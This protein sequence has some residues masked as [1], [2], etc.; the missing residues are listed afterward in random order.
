MS[1]DTNTNTQRENEKTLEEVVNFWKEQHESKSF[2]KKEDW[3]DD[4]KGALVCGNLLTENGPTYQMF[5]LSETGFDIDKANELLKKLDRPSKVAEYI[6]LKFYDNEKAF[7]D[8]QTFIL[9]NFSSMDNLEE[10]VEKVV[11]DMPDDLKETF[12][13][14]FQ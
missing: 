5:I 1:T 7:E 8:F 3:S 2:D 11:E 9:G 12:M 13:K 4:A 14:M 6:H 10:I